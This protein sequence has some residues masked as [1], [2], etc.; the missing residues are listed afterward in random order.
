MAPPGMTFSGSAERSLFLFEEFSPKLE[1]L[2]SS[3]QSTIVGP[4]NLLDK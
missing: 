1:L 3:G 4:S 2:C